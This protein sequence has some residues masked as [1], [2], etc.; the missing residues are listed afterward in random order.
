MLNNKI[1]YYLH[2]EEIYI[3]HDQ[4]NV[5]LHLTPKHYDYEFVK[6]ALSSNTFSLLNCNSDIHYKNY[7][8]LA[9]IK[10]RLIEVDSTFKN[11]YFSSIRMSL[12]KIE[13][14]PFIK[15]KTAPGKLSVINLD[16]YLT[17][18]N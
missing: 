18:L 8:T 11:G 10:N 7:L 14:F 6:K 13:F 3:W 12:V 2:Q 15:T 5:Y 4:S 9:K 1:F 16:Q 17:S